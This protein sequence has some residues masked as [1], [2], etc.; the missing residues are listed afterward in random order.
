[1]VHNRLFHCN[2]ELLSDIDVGLLLII[3][4]AIII[5][6]IISIQVVIFQLTL[7]RHTP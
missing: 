3:S 6:I 1:M 7:A 2:S 4:H 5:V